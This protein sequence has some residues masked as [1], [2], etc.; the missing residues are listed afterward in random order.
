MNFKDKTPVQFAKEVLGGREIS[1]AES[2]NLVKQL[3][4]EHAFGYARKVLARARKSRVDDAQLA[5]WLRQQHALC[6]YKDPDLPASTR[7][8]LALEILATGEDLG[9]TKDQETLGLAGAIHKR[10]WEVDGQRDHL[11]W[12]LS[13][14]RRGYELGVEPDAGYTAINAAYVADLL[15]VESA[16]DAK[17]G[18]TSQAAAAYR[19]LAR[20]IRED[21]IQTLVPLAEEPA[22]KLITGQWWF[23]CTIAEA[24]F[25]LARYD[26]ASEWLREAAAIEN[27]SE[28]EF[29]STAQQLTKL[30][31]L[32]SAGEVDSGETFRSSPA[33]RTLLA[34]LGNDALGLQSAYLG[35]FGLALSGGGFRASLYHIGVLARLAE[36]DVLRNVEVISCVS[37]GSILG[38]HYYLEV[39]K[40]LESKNDLDITRQDYIDIVR[41]VARDFLA[42]VQRNIRWLVAASFLTNL[43]MIFRPSYSRSDRLGELYEECLYARIQD[44]KGGS[45]RFMKDLFVKPKGCATDFNPKRDNWRRKNKVPTLILNATT[46]NTGHNWQFTA[47]WMGESP[48]SVDPAVDGNYRLRRVYYDDA[49]G[50]EMKDG[51][52]RGVRLGTAVA[53]SACVPG[54]FEP[55][56]LRGVYANKTVRLVDG[57]VHDN[58]GVVGLLE[59][60]CNVLLVSDA[61][62]QMESQDEPSNSVIGV[63]LRSNSI[64]M[65]R[66]REAEYDDLVARRSTSLLRGFM[67]VHLKKDLDV[68]AV[69]WAGCDEPIE[70]SDDARPAELRGPRTRYGIRKSVQRRLAAIRTDLDSF[71]DSEAYAL[72][73]SGYRMTEFEFPRT[74]SGCEAPAEEAVQWPFLA[75]EPAMDRADDSGKLMELLSVA[76]QGAFKVWKLYPPLRILAWILVAVLAACAAWWLWEKRDEAVI[77]Y[78]TIGVSLLVLIASTVLGKS[79]MR[80]VR[81]RETVTKILFGI[82][83]ALIGF[84]V[85]KIHLAFF[86]KRFLKLGRIKRLLP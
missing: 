47:S 11:E 37:G 29:Q 15:G 27:V 81:F 40:L 38:A 53:A 72:M 36:L 42:G 6:T 52:R 82:G 61:S 64:L 39:Q 73:V 25:G 62:G 3:K 71:S 43:K 44:G 86:D 57:G 78:Q 26:Q 46:L 54:L 70:A 4:D 32:Q 2:R 80:I 33:G 5:I 79:V 13:F 10:M 67:F 22:N 51:E 28:W 84:F 30:A 63:P 56:V 68:E 41:R 18:L 85:A 55:I 16:A 31:R 77:T 9:A 19:K 65:S 69:N 20:T 24:Y 12:S 1:V 8:D 7:F 58:Q 83:M 75:V 48:W 74:V 14:Y 66:V 59:Q 76:D 49:Q 21:I 60:D 45:E 50:I 34:F 23:V 17:G 35:K